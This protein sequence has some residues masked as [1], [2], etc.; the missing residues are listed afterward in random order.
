MQFDIIQITLKNA[1]QPF[2]PVLYPS[3]RDVESIW[4]CVDEEL[5]QQLLQNLMK[6]RK[7]G[8][9]FSSSG[10]SSFDWMGAGLTV[11]EPQYRP[12]TCWQI[13]PNG[14]GNKSAD[15]L[16]AESDAALTHS[17]GKQK[18]DR[19]TAF[20]GHSGIRWSKSRLLSGPKRGG[21][22]LNDLNCFL[23]KT[24]QRR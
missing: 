15:A 7:T 9:T 13:R 14:E 24:D 22:T 4:L 20:T 17:A 18:H 16:P 8:A 5:A 12:D 23:L 3:V 11:R 19:T 21:Q 1:P 2:P 10:N 6:V